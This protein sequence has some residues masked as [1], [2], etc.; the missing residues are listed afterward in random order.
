MTLWER[1]VFQ[2]LALPSR[3]VVVLQN[4]EA[5]GYGRSVRQGNSLNIEDL[6][7]RPEL[8]SQGLGTQLIHGLLR[9]GLEDGATT[10]HLTVNESNADARR[11]YER[12]GFRN[13]YRYRYLIP[14]G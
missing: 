3:F 8:R 2:R 6:W 7:M 5:C 11:L 1:Q 10:A 9:L 14:K 4:G 13:K 12:L